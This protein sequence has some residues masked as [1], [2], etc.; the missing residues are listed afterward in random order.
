M[1]VGK[2]PSPSAAPLE[3][4]PCGV[5]GSG[6]TTQRQLRSPTAGVMNSRPL[7]PV[8]ARET[9]LPRCLV[10]DIATLCRG[11]TPPYTCLVLTICRQGC[12]CLVHHL[13]M[14]NIT[15][16]LCARTHRPLAHLAAYSHA[17]ARKSWQRV[18]DSAHAWLLDLPKVKPAT[19]D[20][21][22]RTLPTGRAPPP[23]GEERIPPPPKGMGEFVSP[24]EEV[25]GKASL[26]DLRIVT[27]LSSANTTHSMSL[28]LSLCVE[29]IEFQSD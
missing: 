22:P 21:P 16:L 11:P 3:D 28:F 4:W 9:P 17:E 1:A 20:A 15:R 8:M 5:I 19:H 27:Q 2:C 26:N 7:L 29:E 14:A 25:E 12:R 13:W 24:K 6:V 18:P 23:K 10:Q